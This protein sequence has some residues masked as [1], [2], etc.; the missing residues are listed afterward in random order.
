MQDLKVALV[1]K[2]KD[3]LSAGL[4][5]IEARIQSLERKEQ[6][7]SQENKQLRKEFDKL[8]TEIKQTDKATSEF[9][10]ELDQ[11][12]DKAQ[13]TSSK[14]AFITKGIKGIGAIGGTAL[15]TGAV[16][17]MF[18]LD[19][20]ARKVI[21][22][23]SLTRKEKERLVRDIAM[24]RGQTLASYEEISR[25]LTKLIQETGR[26]DQETVKTAKSVLMLRDLMDNWDEAEIT[27]AITQMQKAWG[28]TGEQAAQLIYTVYQKAGDKA[29]DLLDTFWEYAPALAEAGIQAEEFAAILIAGAKEG[30]FNYDKIADSMKEAFR[31]RLVEAS[32]LQQILGDVEKQQAGL[33]DQLWGEG[34]QE[35][36]KMKSAL[37]DYIQAVQQGNKGLAKSSFVQ[38]VGVITEAY[39]KDAIKTKELLESIFGAMGAEDLATDV[40]KAIGKATADPQKYLKGAKELQKSW[41]EAQDSLTRLQIAWT[42]VWQNIIISVKPFFD[43]LAKGLTLVAEFAQEHRTLSTV[44]VGGVAVIGSLGLAIKG[45]SVAFGVA[46]SGLMTFLAPFRLF[47][48]ESLSTCAIT[49]GLSGC[50]AEKGRT[51]AIAG[52]RFRGFSRILGGIGSRAIA[53]AGRFRLL[54]GAGKLLLGGLRLLSLTN[55]L[56][57]ALTAVTIFGP[58]L[59]NLIG[60]VEGLRKAFSKV[61]S[62]VKAAFQLNPI[63]LFLKGLNA[64]KSKALELGKALLSGIKGLWN[65]AKSVGASAITKGIK[66]VP[67]I[68]AGYELG[69]TIAGLMKGKEKATPQL[70]EVNR[71][72]E[73]TTVTQTAQSATLAP[74][75]NITIPAINVASGDP[76][77]VRKA[78]V[79]AIKD[80]SEDILSA[81]EGLIKRFLEKQ[82]REF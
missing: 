43:V 10:K 21:F 20:W 58:K 67:I 29:G 40:L 27:R 79:E 17:G 73:A 8:E 38:L 53:L 24:L 44:L 65:K 14:L 70:A 12:S 51:F 72:E 82:S 13:E 66:Y 61:G 71:I 3:Y 47:K 25:V 28:I 68:G 56:G 42:S 39:K 6:E 74:S 59:W 50:I 69:K 35:W 63:G 75:I 81:F 46:K 22:S 5:R 9:T 33:I 4:R 16:K 32:N 78:V 19:R 1:T 76:T 64:I 7:L 60:G 37:I 62:A 52:S 15:L 36:T 11:L 49:K 34:S 23:T 55:P 26:Y 54:T 77:E 80:S 41:E 2:L 57:L 30:A 31:A 48:R 45:L 18:E